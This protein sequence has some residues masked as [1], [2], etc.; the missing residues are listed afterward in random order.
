VSESPV[1][2]TDSDNSLF[3]SFRS[4]IADMQSASARIYL[5]AV[6]SYETYLK[7]RDE[8]P[9]TPTPALVSDWIV[10]LSRQGISLKTSA[11]YLDAI[12]A[13]YSK[14]KADS[15]VT[16]TFKEL[17]KSI[18]AA[19]EISPCNMV[20]DNRFNRFV[21]ITRTATRLTGTTS[22]ACDLMLYSLLNGCMPLEQVAQLQRNDITAPELE[23]LDII[24]RNQSP[25]RRYIFDLGQSRLTPNQLNQK[26]ESIIDNFL[27]VNLLSVKNY[28]PQQA[29]ESYWTY[30]AIKKGI[31]GSQIIA[32][33]G[34]VPQG[35]PV[36][37]LYSHMPFTPGYA[38]EL[39]CIIGDTFV[40]NPMHWY[41]MRLR[42]KVSY[43]DITHRLRQIKDIVD[44]PEMFY[45][46][47][48][49]ARRTNHKLV[50]EKRPVIADIIFFRIHPCDIRILFSHIG[51][52]AWC[53][54][55]TGRPGSSYAIIPNAAFRTFQ[56]TIGQFTPQYEVAP[57][58][59]LES[60]PGDKVI[61]I[62]GPLQGQHA[63]LESIEASD[64][65]HT[66][67]R[68]HLMGNN[69]IEWRVGIDSRL[70]APA[71]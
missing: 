45:P 13:L 33:L 66:I 49:I 25:R 68:I 50:I 7:I 2:K 14:T 40:D 28:S 5:K 71:I 52:L 16:G 61:V 54:T 1:N 22:I 20:D 43:D 10:D 62:G 70:V 26:I 29:I 44:T 38:P 53:Y 4:R 9:L 37:T 47:E 41:A 51:D 6:K 36:L 31:P 59:A 12:A 11:L 58:G 64:P 69:G 42:P 65:S 17:K 39:P 27:Y 34:H 19:L 8:S 23:S 21:N 56:E 67:Y 55:T 60:R 63:S 18:K 57:I 30:A 3:A 48:E 46:C 24:E 35:Y 32:I 15:T